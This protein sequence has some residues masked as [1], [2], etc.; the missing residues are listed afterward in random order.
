MEA[1]EPQPRFTSRHLALAVILF[2]TLTLR[3]CY[4]V[5]HE[6]HPIGV[7]ADM[8]KSSDMHAFVVWAKQ[9]AAGD[10]L[11][12]DTYHPYMDWMKPIAPLEQFETWWGGK[13]VYHQNPL[14]AYVLAVSYFVFDSRT[15]VLLLQV[16]M[17]VLGVFL[18]YDIGRRLLDARA[19]LIAAGLAAVYAPSIVFDAVTLRASFNTSLTL[20]SVWLLMR[21]R[22]QPARSLA[23]GAGVCLAASYMLRPTGLALMVVGPLL[24][25]LHGDLRNTWRAWLP[26]IGLG[27][28]LGMAPFVGRNLIVGAPVLTFSTRGPETVIQSHSRGMDPGFMMVQPAPKYRELME[29]GHGSITR[30]IGA[31]IDS[32]PEENAFG[33]WLWHQWQKVICVFRDYEYQNNVNYYYLA[34]LT[35][36]LGVLPTF[37]WIVG[38]GLVGLV[39]LGVYGRDRKTALIPLAAVGALF[40]GSI[41]GFALGRYRLPLAVMLTIPAGAT[42]SLCYGWVLAG[43]RQLGAAAG[44]LVAAVAISVVSYTVVPTVSVFFPNGIVFIGGT[45]R[46]TKEQ[47]SKLRPQEYMLVADEL[48]RQGDKPGAAK[49]VEDFL[50]RY[51]EFHNTTGQRLVDSALE[52]MDFARS[53]EVLLMDLKR[54]LEHSTRPSL[55]SAMSPAW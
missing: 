7:T 46:H 1:G 22:E 49:V 36:I 42:L 15:P 14:Y 9:I 16:L 3:S 21:L 28:A 45:I 20:L 6:T 37:G 11:C 35:P 25:L 53:K 18:V 47:S 31:A 50:N 38:L 32:W 33:W 55:K 40:L 4:L 51:I 27:V 30:A 24:L 26:M 44:S 48:A 41:L 29:N 43:G 12:S 8:A 17:S 52:G 19:G 23:L 13:L 54:A 39:L 2:C 34:E 5:V 10:W